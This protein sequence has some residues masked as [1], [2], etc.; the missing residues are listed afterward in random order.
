M[1]GVSWCHLGDLWV[2]WLLCVLGDPAACQVGSPEEVLSALWSREEEAG[3]SAA[4][5]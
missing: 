5:L 1:L 3:V 4:G 2:L